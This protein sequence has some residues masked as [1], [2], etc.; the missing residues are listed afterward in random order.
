MIALPPNEKEQ[1]SIARVLSDVDYLIEALGSLIE[2]KKCIKQ[3]AMQELLTGKKRLFGDWKQSDCYNH[4]EIGI[5]S[6]DWEFRMLD[7]CAD[8]IDPHPSHRAPP[9]NT[10]GIPFV[11]IGDLSIN[12]DFVGNKFR[13]VD[14]QIYDEHSQRYDLSEGLIGIGRVASIGKV[15]RLKDNIGKFV[16]SPTLAVIKP[17]NI[18][19][20]FLFYILNSEYV[21]DQFDIIKN[22][23]TRNSIGIMTLRKILVPVPKQKKEQVKIAKVLSDMDSEIETLELKRK[24]YRLLK[25]G[26]MQQLLTGRIRLKC[27]S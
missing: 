10:Y 1:C 26:L 20:N 15:V 19:K 27:P 21:T 9:L 2:K 23:S 4:T 6:E 12:G 13:L 24:K 8:I 5:I 22:G 3:G 11:G 7:K 18:D 14:E 25:V 16:I 17:K